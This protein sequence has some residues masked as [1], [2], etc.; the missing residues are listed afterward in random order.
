MIEG[1]TENR[2]AH[3]ILLSLTNSTQE[4]VP[5]FYDTYRAFFS[6]I[7]VRPI[8]QV[9]VKE[10]PMLVMV[11]RQEAID[12]LKKTYQFYTREELQAVIEEVAQDYSSPEIRG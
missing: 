3:G 12:Y 1:Q 7:K 11:N 10:Q 6:P 4:V 2:L 8:E 5:M 9:D